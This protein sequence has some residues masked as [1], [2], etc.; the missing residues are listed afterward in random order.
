MMST[1][2]GRND[3]CPC[4]S[5][6][7]YKSCCLDKLQPTP[8]A[9][10]KAPSPQEINVLVSLFNQ[11]RYAEAESLARSMTE[12]FP[13]DGFG[14]KMLGAA[15]MQAGRSEDALP[16]MQKAALL[17]PGDA[18]AHSNLSNALINLGR[19]EEAEAS[20]RQAIKIRPDFAG[21]H[22]NLGLILKHL[23]RLDKAEA[24]YR[25]AISLNSDY[26][27]A[28]GNLGAVLKEQG[29][30]DDAL[31]CFQKQLRLAPEDAEVSHQIASLTGNNTERAPVEYVENVFD[32]YADRFD[33]HLQQV[34]KYDAPGKLVELVT[35]HKAPPAEKWSVLDLGCGTGLAGLAVAPFARRLVGVDLSARMLNKAHARNLYQRLERQDLLTM[36]RRELA[37]SYDVIIAADVFIYLGKLDEI[38]SEIKRLLAPGGIFAFSIEALATKPD[39]EA[40]QNQREYQLEITGRYS[41][42]PDYMVRLAS[43]NDLLIQEMVATQIRIEHGKPVNGYLIL[44]TNQSR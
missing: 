24:S 11:H 17:A 8:V 22:N 2:T 30:L 29:K 40:A 38:I 20:C 16:H 10:P 18:G 34:L 35:Q 6:K 5:G 41:H 32:D 7:K 3:P 36:M 42:S 27:N 31:S 14:W 1:K 12:N 26:A 44:W 15:L 19:H 39:E 43:T 23:G 4:G 37:G 9:A 21:G 13:R 28:Y 33:I 25:R